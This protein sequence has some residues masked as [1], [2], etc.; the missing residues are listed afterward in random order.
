MVWVH[1]PIPRGEGHSSWRHRWYP[2]LHTPP[3]TPSSGEKLSALGAIALNSLVMRTQSHGL[4]KMRRSGKCALPLPPLLRRSMIDYALLHRPILPLFQ[5][6]PQLRQRPL[7]EAVIG[8]L[9]RQPLHVSILLIPP[10]FILGMR[11]VVLH[12]RIVEQISPGE[13]CRSLLRLSLRAMFPWWGKHSMTLDLLLDSNGAPCLI[14]FATAM[15]ASPVFLV[16]PSN[17]PASTSDLYPPFSTN[18]AF[19]SG[20]TPRSCRSSARHSRT[21]SS[22]ISP[23]WVP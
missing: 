22:S 10:Q 13:V 19:S 17:K 5:D 15:S 1:V 23:S 12:W 18:F 11:L 6:Q 14:H 7:L 2:P 3:P 20:S 9:H 8:L 4:G 21:S 16:H